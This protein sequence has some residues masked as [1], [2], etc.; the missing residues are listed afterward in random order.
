MSTM[1]A[2]ARDE[3]HDV[4]LEWEVELDRLDLEV[5]RVE[6]LLKAMKPMEHPDWV[7]PSPSGPMP[8]HLLPRAMEIHRRQTAML[9]RVLR[10]MRSTTLHR[11]YVETLA[12]PNDAAPR[13]VN[14]TG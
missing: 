4:A 11:T 14:V 10:A 2:M 5:I 3:R 9:E 12:D 8:P 7:A 1:S 6:R 13:Y